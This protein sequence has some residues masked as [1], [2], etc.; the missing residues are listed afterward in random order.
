MLGTI[1]IND[2]STLTITKSSTAPEV[3]IVI[4]KHKLENMELVKSY[5]S[6]IDI[7]N[8]SELN[9]E[10]INELFLHSW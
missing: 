7:I 10:E 2:K 9:T 1:T 4:M 6:L 3:A 8:K 5:A